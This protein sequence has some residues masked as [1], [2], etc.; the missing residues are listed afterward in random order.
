MQCNTLFTTGTVKKWQCDDLA[1][2]PLFTWVDEKVLD[3]PTFRTFKRLLD[4]YES[5]RGEAEEVTAEEERENW[6]F[7]DA[8][9]DTKVC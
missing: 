1:A 6:E 7:I 3:R 9:M 5:A 2:D 4:N 8:C